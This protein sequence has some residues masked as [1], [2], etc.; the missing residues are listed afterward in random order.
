LQKNIIFDVGNVLLTWNP[1]QII[2]EAFK[3]TEHAG[4]FTP[5]MFRLADWLAF[6]QGLVTERQV[7]EKLQA[8]WGLTPEL[9]DHALY[10]AKKSLTPKEG[11]IELLEELDQRKKSGEK[12][13]LF[14]LTNMSE[15]FFEF[16]YKK[17]NF[18]KFFKHITVSARVKL[19]KPDPRIYH[20]VL[21]HNGLL[22]GQTILIDDMKENIESAVRTGLHGIEFIN[23][24]DC[25]EK[26]E[27]FLFK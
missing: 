19:L 12:I 18:W 9:A 7:S 27:L 15:E 25:R 21:N 4:K 20:F 16:L 22:A 1:D 26:L 24:Q 10:T 3:N 13:E 8:Q 14:C 2:Q 6:D 5:N 11:S 23:I 17:Y